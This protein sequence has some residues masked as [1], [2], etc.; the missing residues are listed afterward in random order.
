[1]FSIVAAGTPT[2]RRNFSARSKTR[3]LAACV[4]RASVC[5]ARSRCTSQP[6]RAQSNRVETHAVDQDVS[7]EVV[8]WR[9]LIRV[10][11]AGRRA[12][13]PLVVEAPTEFEACKDRCE[14]A[15]HVDDQHLQFRVGGQTRR[16]R[17]SGRR[18]G[19]PRFLRL[20]EHLHTKMA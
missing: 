15:A 13:D 20:V 10:R 6:R 9:P 18:L 3:P 19:S 17:S 2:T 16:S 8:G 14:F 4:A 5:S 12:A 11:L 7:L 1:M